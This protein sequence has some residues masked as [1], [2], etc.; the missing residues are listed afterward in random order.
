MDKLEDAFKISDIHVDR[1][2]Y[3]LKQLRQDYPFPPEFLSD[4]PMEKAADIELLTSRFAKLQDYMGAQ[5]FPLLL[6]KLGEYADSMTFIDKLNKLEKFRVIDSAVEWRKMR[7]LR[8]H[9]AHEYP[10]DPTLMAENL[11]Q[12]YKMTTKLLEELEQVKVFADK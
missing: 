12:T 11:N 8:N 5:I 4:L 6:Q 3:A 1:L 2:R 7:E 10:D 9:I